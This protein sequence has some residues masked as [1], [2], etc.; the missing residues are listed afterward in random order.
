MRLRPIHLAL[1]AI[2][3]VAAGFATVV[4]VAA[5]ADIPNL[6]NATLTGVFDTFLPT[7]LM[8]VAFIY[9]DVATSTPERDDPWRAGIGLVTTLLYLI[10]VCWGY[11][12]FHVEADG[13]SAT[14]LG[15]FLS[16][17][18]TGGEPVVVVVLGYY[19]ANR[20][21]RNRD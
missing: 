10:L 20:V 16:I 5:R 14:D 1:I 19:F 8:M 3:L 17:V 13:M 21:A 15:E 18:R 11:Y 6:F 12:Q 2:W 9:A 7:L 4:V